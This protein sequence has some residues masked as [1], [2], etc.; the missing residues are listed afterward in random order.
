MQKSM[1]EMILLCEQH[2]S[3]QPL[4][5][6]FRETLPATKKQRLLNFIHYC[7]T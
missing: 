2:F 7:P 4:A 3:S 6:A 5:L 1:Q